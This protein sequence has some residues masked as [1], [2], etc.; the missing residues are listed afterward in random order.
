MPA[1]GRI[2]AGLVT[3]GLFVAITPALAGAASAQTAPP[4]PPPPFR[5]TIAASPTTLP[6]GQTSHVTVTSNRSVTGT[7][8]RIQ[9]Y[10]TSFNPDA[11]IGTCATGTTCTV[12]V[13]QSIQT[14]HTYRG[15]ITNGGI[16]VAGSVSNVSYVTWANS[17]WRISLSTNTA[18]PTGS[19]QLTATANKSVS[20]PSP[21]FIEIFDENGTLVASCGAGS[22]CPAT[23]NP[24]PSTSKYVAFVSDSST[25]LLPG[26]I[27]ASS[28]VVFVTHIIP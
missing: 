25:T 16:P 2:R 22:S 5:T 15:R 9:V 4:P 6:V 23:V 28:N 7:N 1:R 27:Q 21:Y 14:T 24:S 3:V 19:A 8:F 10:D 12:P 26:T 13:K 18:V 20:P 17:G 11:E